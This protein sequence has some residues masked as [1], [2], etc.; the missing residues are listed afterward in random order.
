E[1]AIHLHKEISE[2]KASLCNSVLTTNGGTHEQ[3][4]R[5]GV[6]KSIR[7]IAKFKNNKLVASATADEILSNASYIL[8]VFISNP[9]FEGQTKS[10]L[11]SSY[12]QKYCDVSI[13][14]SVEE[15]FNQHPKA[16]NSILSFIEGKIRE[17]NL[18]DQNL[19]VGRQSVTRKIRLPGKLADCTSSKVEGTE[20]FIVEGDSAG[21]SAKQARDRNFQAILPLRGKILNVK[22]S[23]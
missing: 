2:F 17:K 1:F 8:S 11:S 15:W 23:N 6:A 5:T 13:A 14:K 22:N 9:E 10:R 18:L 4:F 3:G 21:G 12:I 16:S 7:K 20:L 19:D